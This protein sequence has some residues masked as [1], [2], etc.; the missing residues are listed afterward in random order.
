MWRNT[1]YLAVMMLSVL[2]IASAQSVSLKP[3]HVDANLRAAIAVSGQFNSLIVDEGRNLTLPVWVADFTPDEEVD[4][5]Q[6]VSRSF[7]QLELPE[8]PGWGL[9]TPAGN[10]MQ[11]Q[12]RLTDTQGRLG[13]VEF[14]DP[15]TWQLIAS[16][17]AN[18]QRTEV[19]GTF[20]IPWDRRELVA[21]VLNDTGG[22]LA[23][24]A[25]DVGKFDTVVPVLIESPFEPF[26]LEPKGCAHF[27][28]QPE[29]FYGTVGNPYHPPGVK[30]S[31]ES[32]GRSYSTVY[33]DFANDSSGTLSIYPPSSLWNLWR[34]RVIADT[35][36]LSKFRVADPQ[37]YAQLSQ[38]LSQARQQDDS[39]PV[40]PVE[41][42][43]YSEGCARWRVNFT[44]HAK[45]VLA[46]PYERK[47]RD[48]TLDAFIAGLATYLATQKGF[49]S[50]LV[51]AAA[52]NWLQSEANQQTS[53]LKP[54]EVIA[55]G[56]VYSV[57]VDSGKDVARW[58]NLTQE[59]RILVKVRYPD[60]SEAP[61]TGTVSITRV[62]PDVQPAP[63]PGPVYE[64]AVPH[65]GVTVQV[66][67]GWK[68]RFKLTAGGDEHIYAIPMVGNPPTV[69]LY[70]QVATPPS[71][72]PGGE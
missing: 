62:E 19:S 17:W 23:R 32:L 61:A 37:S 12:V 47:K 38:A 22:V 57:V 58:A 3:L 16:L 70:V 50:V 2:P 7:S 13:R 1:L 18:A 20:S 54:G 4:F 55:W 63:P 35:V 14:R 44:G 33:L 39:R 5:D 21:E 28:I 15:E 66:G 31:L 36:N 51:A 27:G 30:I 11:L 41:A 65:E 6:I 24:L 60:G 71:Q 43:P 49:L 67:K 59:V 52:N 34:K 45:A 56:D 64:V 68:Y 9:F 48:R 42:L 29:D 69:T 53:G 10:F 46:I 40:L 8:E 26:C 72:P 25:V